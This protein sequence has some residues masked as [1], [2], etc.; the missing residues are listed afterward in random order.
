VTTRG[1]ARA[2]LRERAHRELPEP[3]DPRRLIADLIELD[4]AGLEALEVLG[5][6]TVAW[7]QLRD[8]KLERAWSSGFGWFLARNLVLMG[9]VVLLVT[10]SLRPPLLLVE[11]AL[12][13]AAAYYL[14]VLLLSP[15]RLRR[16]K[17][18]RAAILES[19]GRDLAAYLESLADPGRS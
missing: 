4:A 10:A 19:Y 3:G 5:R 18:R 12:G 11:A 17:R 7:T 2:R 1:E 6:V 9:V 14:L 13:G 16:H 8:L 15:L